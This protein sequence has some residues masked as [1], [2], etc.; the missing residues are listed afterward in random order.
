M[1]AE[2]KMQSPRSEKD[3]DSW[4]EMMAFDSSSDKGWNSESDRA[5]DEGSHDS[6]DIVEGNQV[7]L[8]PNLH[9]SL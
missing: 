6:S 7:R 1:Y 4:D 8:S 9:Y 2:E 3:E 5:G